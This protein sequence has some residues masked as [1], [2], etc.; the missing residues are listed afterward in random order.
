MRNKVKGVLD[1]LK[2]YFRRYIP[3]VIP[4]EVVCKTIGFEGPS[5]LLN[6]VKG[7]TDSRKI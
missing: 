1:T 5:Y 3:K 4:S 2:I 6:S 7:T